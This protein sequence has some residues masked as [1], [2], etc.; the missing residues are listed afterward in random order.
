MSGYTID[1]VHPALDLVNSQHGRSPDLLDDEDWF[2]GF[3][4]QWG[5]A[6]AGRPTRRERERLVAL[7]ALMRGIVEAV[8]EGDGP[9]AT[10]LVQLNRVLRAVRASRELSTA[11]GTFELR[12]VPARRDW[13]WVLSELA[14]SLADLLADGE[15]DRLKVCDNPDCRFAFYDASKNR[16]RRWC[17]HTTCGNRNKVKQFRARQRALGGR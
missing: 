11:G 7:R 12:L 14:A 8:D 6:Q 3:A 10:Q 9:N 1:L 17:A 2:D 5:Y 4:R 13:T 16:S 15:T